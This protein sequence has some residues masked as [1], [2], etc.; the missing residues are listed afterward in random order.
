[1]RIPPELAPRQRLGKVQS[2]WQRWLIPHLKGMFQ[3]VGTLPT[4]SNLLRFSPHLGLDI[5]EIDCLESNKTQVPSK[6]ASLSSKLCPQSRRGCLL[7]SL[8]VSD[9]FENL[10]MVPFPQGARVLN[11]FD[12]FKDP[13]HSADRI[14]IHWPHFYGLC[15]LGEENAL[16]CVPFVFLWY[17]SLGMN[18]LLL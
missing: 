11:V 5:Q 10:L 17:M 1:M 2:A 18:A 3:Q 7:P 14:R 9:T 12:E 8:G 15:E 6:N 16:G 4:L 13:W